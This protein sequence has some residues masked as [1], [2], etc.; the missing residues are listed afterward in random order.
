MS[1]GK[2]NDRALWAKS[3]LAHES[4]VEDDC[5]SVL[6]IFF[7]IISPSSSQVLPCTVCLDTMQARRS[8]MFRIPIVS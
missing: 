6:D 4:E 3:I 5:F 1:V 8:A 2:R 7:Y